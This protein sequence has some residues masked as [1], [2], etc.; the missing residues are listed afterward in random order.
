M[1]QTSRCW[2]RIRQLLV[3]LLLA[4]VLPSHARGETVPT[5]RAGEADGAIRIDGVLD[6]P[7]WGRAGRIANLTQQEPEPGVPT[8]HDTEVLV[9]VD[10][11]NL[12]IG[13]I[14]H[15]PNPQ[16]IIVHTMQHDGNFSGDKIALVFDTFGD[17]RR[18]YYFE[19]NAVGACLE[20]LISGPE[21]F[22]A[23][24][25]GIW[26]AHTRRTRDGWIAEIR[27][28]AQTLRFTPG[29]ESWGF[30]VERW[31][32]RDRI[33]L[34]WAGTSLDAR[35][36]DLRRAGRL[37]GIGRLRQGR[38]LGISPYGLGRRNSDLATDY[39]TVELDG[40]LDITYNVT[41]RVTAVLTLNSDFSET[42]VDNRQ[43]NLT[44]FPLFL[45][46]KRAF[47]LKGSNLFSFGAGLHY[48]FI[49]FFSRRIGLYQGELVPLRG[50][51]K[52]LGQVG[53]WSLAVLDAVMGE[54]ALTERTNL[55]AGRL[56]Y[57]VTEHLTLGTIV[58]DGDPR[59]D[60]DNT[61]V[62]VDAIWQTSTFR[63]EK[64][65]SVGGWFTWT[66]RDTIGGQPTG[67][68]LKIDYPNDLWDVFFIY[69]EFGDGLNPALGFLPRPGTRWY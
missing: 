67:W 60:C 4:L 61:L 6:E 7:A 30:N 3:I 14:C 35:F 17:Q 50:G 25:D 46:E 22:S 55:L 34:R 29:A 1:I 33:V 28:P 9:L 27:I 54:S 58:T 26:D 57:D 65:L 64:N 32:A 13:V 41:P 63:G 53:K 56:L 48:D 18:G 45:P 16:W 66:G 47:F 39:S 8:P 43:I 5:V 62:G 49:P 21:E 68:G 2:R 10:D 20:G 38:G 23:D 44:R 51:V 19:T 40:G 59:G 42:E 52:V 11:E 36:Q 24:W 15:D 31:V 37:E 12:Y 69:K